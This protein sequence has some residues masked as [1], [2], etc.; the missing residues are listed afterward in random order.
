MNF[1]IATMIRLM[2][3][4]KT[5]RDRKRL[6][7]ELNSMLFLV[8]KGHYE[9]KELHN[10][11]FSIVT[12]LIGNIRTKDDKYWINERVLIVMLEKSYIET[13]LFLPANPYKY[14]QFLN[15]LIE[16]SGSFK[17]KCAICRH[18]ILSQYTIKK[19]T[20]KTS[21]GDG[22]T[23]LQN[24]QLSQLVTPLLKLYSSD[25]DKLALLACIALINLSLKDNI[26]KQKL[27]Q[28]GKNIIIKKLQT[29]N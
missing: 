16:K 5:V 12:K 4:L 6:Y 21:K 23:Q 11:I 9:K 25:I 13:R 7:A 17:I 24:Q 26:I 10:D 1:G 19:N 3:S 20:V 15:W 8:Q 27:M 29:K 2:K 14:P 22:L 18:L 28:E